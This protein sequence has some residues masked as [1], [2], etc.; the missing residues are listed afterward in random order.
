MKASI[1]KALRKGTDI[2][3]KIDSHE[4]V[5]VP[6]VKVKKPGGG[7]AVEP[8]TPRA[9]Q[10]FSVEANESALSGLTGSAGGVTKGEGT[11]VHTW[12]Y[13]L[14]GRYDAEVEIG[15]T[16]TYQG[17]VYRVVGIQP[18]NDYEKRA[19]VSAIGAEPSY[20]N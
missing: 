7:Y 11:E 19:V 14:V 15:D 1:L 20:G 17:V 16:W 6:Q 8:G 3:L 10:L 9:L 4:I 18:L 13:Q 5:L 12:A 2:G